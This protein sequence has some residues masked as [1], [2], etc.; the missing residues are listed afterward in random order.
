MALGRRQ[1]ERSQ[2][3]GR[4][5]FQPL[6]FLCLL[7]PLAAGFTLKACQISRNV[8]KCGKR[9]LTSVPRDVPSTVT[10]WELFEN[11]ISKIQLSDF[12]DFPM[13]TQLEL[14]RNMIEQIEASTFSRLTSLKMLN[15]NQNR[16]V[17]L[18]EHVFSGLVNLTELRISQ[19]RI[20]VVANNT[21]QTLS[22]LTIL[23]IS[24]NN[25]HT[26]AKVHMI[27]KQ[28]PHLR[29]LYL[30]SNDFTRFY[31]WELTNTSLDI[32]RLDLSLN[33]MAVFHLTSNVLPNLT[34]FNMTN[35]GWT[36]QMKLDVQ[37]PT[38]F[39]QVSI[40]DISGIHVS[41][42][43]L[44]TLLQ[45]VNASLTSLRMNKM[46]SHLSSLINASCTI[47]TLT[48]LLLQRNQLSHI[49]SDF[50][51]IC[52]N[53]TDVDF[54]HNNIKDIH[55]DA[56]RSLQ[57]LTILNLSYNKLPS[58][59]AAIRTL[60]WLKKLYLS[61]NGISRVERQDFANQSMLEELGLSKNS[62]SSLRGAVFEDLVRLQVL[63]LTDNH[64]VHLDGVFEVHL[65]N[66][67]QLLL[68]GNELSSLQTGGFGGL[69]SLQSLKLHDNKL[70]S[71]QKGCFKGLTNLTE[72]LLQNNQIT[73]RDLNNGCFNDLT[74]LRRL[75][76]RNN[77][78]Y[79]KD[80][81][82]LARPPFSQLSLLRLLY[83]LSQHHHGKSGLPRNFL[84][85]L[86]NLELFDA[87]N[88][89]L[90]FLHE[91]TFNFTPQLQE[92][93]LSSNDL[94]DLSPDLFS[95]L[96]NLRTLYTSRISLGSLQYLTDAKLHKLEFLQA[97][98]NQFSVIDEDVVRS[99]PAL[100][101]LDLQ[102]NTFTCD[103]T[104]AW[105]INWVRTN[106]QT[107]VFDAYNFGCNFPTAS[108]GSKLLDLD[109][110]SCTVD[111]DYILFVSTTS[112]VLLLMVTSF[113]YHFLKAHLVYAYFLFLALVFDK[114]HRNKQSPCQFDAFVSYNSHDE[115]WVVGE[116]LPR[117]EGDQGW[118]LCL[119]HRDFQPGER[120]QRSGTP[121]IFVLFLWFHFTVTF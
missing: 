70:N 107:Q 53:I 100:V 42:D 106:N 74:N 80:T 27:I 36:Q 29:E 33:P 113:T 62:I 28:L 34:F 12:R 72:L 30:G 87:R 21:F 102:G 15:L 79:Y 82:A 23:D 22:S 17:K 84:Q 45:T 50:V 59:P 117:L 115:A 90:V 108:K 43:D 66:L 32:Q 105:F 81:T 91:N 112:L 58:V 83:I 41:V 67:K 38:F 94:D 92:L 77:H 65:P 4:S 68:Q 56:F 9:K 31:S 44:K 51:S 78:I 97:R 46:K 14:N 95:P 52:S 69:P 86:T 11:K 119:H 16:L 19:N 85:G 37:N 121:A 1:K 111:V 47:P 3:P 64:M 104:N 73:E 63:K 20:K 2:T 13:L 25:L 39:H 98:K 49:G 96:R 60:P 61:T 120:V 75:D 99:L 18:E 7:L 116:M 55:D 6:V 88:I 89:Q 54:S 118:K 114:K 8:A 26:M 71:L 10:G 40:L 109:V 103:C 57:R 101:Y 48:Q 24:R 93:D 110:Q 76:L 5:L 35:S